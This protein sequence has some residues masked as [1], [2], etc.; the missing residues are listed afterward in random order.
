M[1]LEALRVYKIEYLPIAQHDLI[2]IVQYISHTLQNPSAADR[3]ATELIQSIEN[4]SLFPYAHSSYIPVRPLKHEYRKLLVKNYL[5]FYWIN[6]NDK[7]I[8]IARVIY[9]RRNYI[10]ALE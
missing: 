3:L 9:S 7:I 10:H 4:I 1:L 5:V 8:T 2:E 6:E